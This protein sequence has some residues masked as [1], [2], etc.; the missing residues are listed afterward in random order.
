MKYL[1]TSDLHIHPHFNN[2]LFIDV[3]INYL[4]YVE[5]YCK[6]NDIKTI[7]LLGDIFHISSKI[8][9]EIFIPVFEQFEKMKNNGL[10]LL[11]IPGNHEM[12][13]E[14]KKT[15][16]N[17]LSPFSKVYDC[18]S[19]PDLGDNNVSFHML[20]FKR[21]YDFDEY[22]VK[23]NDNYNVLLTH[24]DIANFKMSSNS[25]SKGVEDRTFL[26]KFD[27]VF[28]GHYHIH[29]HQDS[30]VYIGSP[31]QQNFGEAGDNN[32]GFVIYDSSTNKW[33]LEVYSE[34]PKFKILTPEQSVKEDISNCFIKLKIKDKIDNLS[35]LREILSDR[36][37]LDIKQEFDNSDNLKTMINELKPASNNSINDI[38]LEIMAKETKYDYK[39]LLDI[40]D[41]IKREQ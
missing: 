15:I 18:Y 30:I 23:M 26:K 31:Y 27:Y 6:K 34:A 12:L 25:V 41:K 5:K 24:M 8:N 1:L 35:K 29:Q 32:K 38:V 3:G 2:N 28:S 4:K 9:I 16:L 7:F 11:M 19:V 33:N 36:G 40:F 22:T 10:E 21:K 13:S 14:N 20:P 17:I 39:I 37:A